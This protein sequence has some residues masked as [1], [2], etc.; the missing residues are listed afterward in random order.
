MSVMN[1]HKCIQKGPENA[2]PAGFKSVGFI[3]NLSQSEMFKCED[4]GPIWKTA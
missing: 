2:E 4:S 1:L 3:Q